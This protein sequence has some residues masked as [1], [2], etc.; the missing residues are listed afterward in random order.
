[1][2]WCEG[3]PE[4]GTRSLGGDERAAVVRLR[5][6]LARRLAVR[7]ALVLASPVAAVALVGLVALGL[8]AFQGSDEALPPGLEVVAGLAFFAGFVVGPAAALLS[9]R[10]RW[11]EWRS[12]RT[13]AGAAIA[14]EFAGDGRAVAVLPASGRVVARDGRRADLDE[15]VQ[16]A[17]AAPAPD[18]APTYALAAEGDASRIAEHGLVR[19]PLSPDE[20]EEIRAHARALRRIPGSVWVVAAWWAL[21]A[22]QWLRGAERGNPLVLLLTLALA[23]AGARLWRSRGLAARLDADAEEGWAI[24]ATAGA[25]AGEEG[26]PLS[27]LGWTARGAPAAWRI[28]R[29]R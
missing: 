24:R 16:V 11:R 17:S 18:R 19:R 8:G 25:S 28:G 23:V 20:R 2:R 26:L 27:R 1:M 7:L 12:L 22:V 9:A 29:R 13:D 4:T 15:R 3:L 6:R 14:L 5:S 10:D 21:G